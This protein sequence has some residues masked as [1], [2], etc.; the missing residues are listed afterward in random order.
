M[1]R[2]SGNFSVISVKLA[3][4][5]GLPAYYLWRR[6]VRRFAQKGVRLGIEDFTGVD[7]YAKKKRETHDKAAV[8]ST[9]EFAHPRLC[10]TAI[11]QNQIENLENVDIL[12]F[13]AIDV[14]GKFDYA[15]H[16]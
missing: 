3:K 8:V 10:S 16:L 2:S 5:H 1:I 6:I 13:V 12:P 9:N 7:K 11:L 4:P 14:M 15:Q